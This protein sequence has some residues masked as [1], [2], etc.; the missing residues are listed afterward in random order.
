[1]AEKSVDP[2]GVQ[3][4]DAVLLTAAEDEDLR[5]A[6]EVLSSIGMAAG[7]VL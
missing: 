6:T 3:P 5:I 4:V 7:E 1:M 2:T